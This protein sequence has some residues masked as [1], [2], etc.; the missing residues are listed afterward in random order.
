VRP[1]QKK[2]KKSGQGTVAHARN[3]NHSGGKSKGSWYKNSSGP[4]PETLSEEKLMQKGMVAW[5][6]CLPSNHE[7]LSSNLKYIKN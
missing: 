1:S 3:P 7:A 2:K 4:K 5:L 6:T